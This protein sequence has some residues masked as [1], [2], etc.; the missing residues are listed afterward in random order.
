MRALHEKK[1]KHSKVQTPKC[2][3]AILQVIKITHN[4]ANTRQK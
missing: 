3:N 4:D 1:L 2:T